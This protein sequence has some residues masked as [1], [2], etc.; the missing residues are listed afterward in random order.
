[1][2]STKEMTHARPIDAGPQMSHNIGTRFHSATQG[3]QAQNDTPASIL[4]LKKK[5]ETR[6]STTSSIFKKKRGET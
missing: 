3:S 4:N 5:K 6:N 1:M 2:H